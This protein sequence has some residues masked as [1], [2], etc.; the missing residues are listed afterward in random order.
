M[1][2]WAWW[3]G[4]V[5][6]TA[7]AVVVIKLMVHDALVAAIWAPLNLG[8]M[9]GGFLGSL[10]GIRA[11]LTTG[12]TFD[13][14]RDPLL[15]VGIGVVGGAFVGSLVAVVAS[16]GRAEGLEPLFDNLGPIVMVWTIMGTVAGM[17]VGAVIDWV[18][19]CRR[20]T[21]VARTARAVVALGEPRQRPV[22][23]TYVTIQ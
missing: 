7:T 20:R 2:R 8:I 16:I 6:G 15:N 9:F 17:V 23:T 11:Q 12:H 5:S 3:L 14:R 21:E 4:T 10:I 18:G 1:F 22:Y 19:A 13:V